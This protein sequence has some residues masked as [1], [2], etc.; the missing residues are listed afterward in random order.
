MKEKKLIEIAKYEGMTEGFIIR[1][2]CEVDECV[3]VLCTRDKIYIENIG[4]QNDCIHANDT[5]KLKCKHWHKI[6]RPITL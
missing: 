4:H 3:S 1:G 6:E 5:T 2:Y